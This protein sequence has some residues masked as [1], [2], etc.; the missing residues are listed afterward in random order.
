[1]ASASAGFV[2]EYTGEPAE[3]KKTKTKKLRNVLPW[4]Q[5]PDIS[6]AVAPIGGA[7]SAFPFPIIQPLLPVLL[8]P[9]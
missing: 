1:M 8:E 5:Q 7:T 9:P 2:V 4:S 3:L 6:T